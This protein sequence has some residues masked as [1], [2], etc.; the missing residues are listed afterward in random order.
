MRR[1]TVMEH[2]GS[3]LPHTGPLRITVLD[4]DMVPNRQRALVTVRNL[5]LVSLSG[6]TWVVYLA[7]SCDQ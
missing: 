1:V 5:L 6:D 7:R 3:A 4:P 2:F